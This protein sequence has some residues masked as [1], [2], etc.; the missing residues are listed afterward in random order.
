MPGP[1]AQVGEPP[2][3]VKS[4][5]IPSAA[6]SRTIASQMAQLADG[7]ALGSVALNLGLVFESGLGAIWYQNTTTRM[8]LAPSARNLAS[9]PAGSAWSCPPSWNIWSWVLLA[10]AALG[11]ARPAAAMSET[12]RV[13]AAMTRACSRVRNGGVW[14]W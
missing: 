10:L 4:T 5:L 6:A 12:V 11:S 2:A 3:T 9:A 13:R 1:S 14:A 7:Y 8:E